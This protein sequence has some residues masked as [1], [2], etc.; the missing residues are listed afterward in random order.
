MGKRIDLTG[1]RFGKLVVSS[2]AYS[3]KEDYGLTR[4]VWNCTC[5]CGNTIEVKAGLLRNGHVKSCGCLKHEHSYNF[6]DLSGMRF[7]RLI[8]SELNEVKN[9]RAYWKCQCDCGNTS[10]V[11]SSELKS[12]HT[13]SCGCL[14]RE[15]SRK[16]ATTH[17]LTYTKVRRTWKNM[18]DRCENQNCTQYKDYGGRGISVCQEWHDLEKFARWAY[19]NGFSEEKSRTEQTIERKD[20]NGNYEPNNCC[21]A[22][23]K[24]QAN[25]KR[26]SR[27]VFLQWRKSYGS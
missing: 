4:A 19:E 18:I 22:T 21:F 16:R 5:D 20:V 24:E 10:I 11:V 17:G 13:Q 3:M 1:K 27:K 12:N 15:L 26:N 25:N 6:E 14:Q 7:G 9:G 23:L 8:V 2:Y